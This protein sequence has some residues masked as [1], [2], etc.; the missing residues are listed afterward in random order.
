[1]ALGTCWTISISLERL[2]VV[3]DRGDVYLRWLGHRSARQLILGK[4]TSETTDF[5]LW[6]MVLLSRD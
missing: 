5:S 4:G 3:F 2:V 6:K 1:M